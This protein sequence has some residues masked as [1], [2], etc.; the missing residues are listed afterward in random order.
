MPDAGRVDG[1]YGAMTIGSPVRTVKLTP[2][3]EIEERLLPERRDN[4][5]VCA[6]SRAMPSFWNYHLQPFFSRIEVLLLKEEL[7]KNVSN[8][9][10][11]RHVT[12][13]RSPCHLLVPLDS[14]LPPQTAKALKN[15]S[16]RV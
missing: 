4:K 9:F 7:D 5:T 14:S 10:G 1:T 8:L 16:W 12:A 3:S 13:A 6:G 2:T 15:L 11:G